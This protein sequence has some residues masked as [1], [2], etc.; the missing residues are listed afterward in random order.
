M[1]RFSAAA[2]ACLVASSCAV[3]EPVAV[4]P[5]VDPELP[6]VDGGSAGIPAKTTDGADAAALAPP[7]S[8]H[9]PDA[10]VAALDRP[11]PGDVVIT[12]VMFNPSGPEPRSEW[13]E[14]TNKTSAPLA[15]D[16]LTIV[17][18]A[19]RT[20]VIAS[21]TTLAPGKY[22]VFARDKATAVAQQVPSAAIVYEYGTGLLDTAGVL[23]L[24]STSGGVS[25]KDGSQVIDDAP[26]GPLYSTANGCS[27]QRDAKGSWCYS[28]NAWASGAD[29]GTPGAASDCP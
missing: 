22:V 12:E 7:P 21:G 10:A 26:Y 2:A 17:D 13:F 11:G 6:T 15:L 8:P 9:G 28:A 25:L 20:H 29:K 27:I 24:N 3:S 4:T 5:D 16:G 18:G 19:G 23:L 1:S 14:L